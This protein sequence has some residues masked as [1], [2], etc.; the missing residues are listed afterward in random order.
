MLLGVIMGDAAE[1]R[2]LFR[3]G[4]TKSLSM[5]GWFFSKTGLLEDFGVFGSGVFALID[6]SIKM[7]I[8]R[9]KL[10]ASTIFGE[11]LS[12]R[13]ANTLKNTYTGSSLSFFC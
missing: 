9:E 1:G 11:L 5:V 12:I 3:T 10:L 7:K 2:F 13:I 8:N 4:V 6:A